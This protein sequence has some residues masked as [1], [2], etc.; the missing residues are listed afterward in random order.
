MRKL[1]S[2]GLLAV[3]GAMFVLV[4]LLLLSGCGP[5]YPECYD[6]GHCQEEGRNEYC[7]NGRCAQCVDDSHCVAKFDRSYVCESGSCTRI[8][9]FC[10]PPEFPCPQ[11]Q[12]CR[13]NRC[14]P[15]CLDDSECAANQECQNGRCV[16]K[17]ECVTDADCPDGKI[18]QNNICV[19][20]PGCTFRTIYFDFD[21][22][23]IR[24]DAKA[25]LDNNA[26]C[27]KENKEKDGA[28]SNVLI[29]GHCDERGTEDY[30]LA[31]GKRRAESTSKALQRLG[32]AAK[33]ISTKSRGEYELVVPNASSE[34]DHQR[35]RRA[36]FSVT[37]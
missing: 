12:R 6:S 30:N 36:E 26:A 14:G 8:A 5:S 10:D 23:A 19:T 31:L 17:K 15:E 37:R 29:T 13:S 25:V 22:S 4:P 11:G 35:N 18:C 27:W 3:A 24:S 9:G 16:A 1:R 34:S 7:L 21:E 28:E 2:E 20:P 32:V 33:R